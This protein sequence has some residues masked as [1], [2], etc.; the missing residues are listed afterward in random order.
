VLYEV[1]DKL[2]PPDCM[3]LW[4]IICRLII[5]YWCCWFW[6]FLES[7]GGP[8]TCIYATLESWSVCDGGAECVQPFSRFSSTQGELSLEDCRGSGPIDRS[9]QTSSGDIQVA[10]SVNGLLL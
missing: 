5:K 7:E 9:A 10:Y 2:K 3:R 8:G 6:Q 1:L 4:Y